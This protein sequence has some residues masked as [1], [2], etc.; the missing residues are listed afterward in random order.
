MPTPRRSICVFCGSSSG[1]QPQYAEAAR[2]LGREAAARD[3]RI[4]YGGA[5]VG[6][7][8]LVADSALE[9]GGEVVGVIPR[10][11]VDRE[12]AHAGLTQLL[13]VDT[14]HQRKA[15]MAELADAFV[16]LPGGIGTLEELFEIWTWGQLGLH[17]KPYGV[18]NTAGY[19]TGLFEFLDH[20]CHEG[21]V[22]PSQRAMLHVATD[23]RSL[24]DVLFTATD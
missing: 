20:A 13:V 7:M 23:A 3:L 5:S 4:V 10:A 18:L 19:Y 24:L 2:M 15:R 14:M 1:V 11:L 22:R 12:I 8:G 6:L 21:F 16:A 17:A 9:Q